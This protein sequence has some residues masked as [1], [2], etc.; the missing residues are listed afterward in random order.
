MDEQENVERP[1]GEK[2]LL[3]L[4]LMLLLMGASTG[5]G[6]TQGFGMIFRMK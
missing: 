1:V 6:R 2:E 3:V 4:C 5:C